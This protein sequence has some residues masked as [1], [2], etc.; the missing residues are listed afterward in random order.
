MHTWKFCWGMQRIR[1]A[2]WIAHFDIIFRKRARNTVSRVLWVREE[3]SLS[4]TEFW[5]KL[6]EFCEKLGEFALSHKF[7][8]LRGTHW[9]L[10]PE[11]GEGQRAHWARCLKPCSPKPYSARLRI[12]VAEPWIKYWVRQGGRVRTR[13]FQRGFSNKCLMEGS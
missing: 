4:L 6:G 11:H 13:F 9:V 7:Y 10:S 12:K 5:G 2:K 1:L 8:R 3:N